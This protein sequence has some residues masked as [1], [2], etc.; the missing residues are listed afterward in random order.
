MA[1]AAR[2]RQMAHP[3]NSLISTLVQD[4]GENKAVNSGASRDYTT[5]SKMLWSKQ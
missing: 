2:D 5:R 1:G 3:P 4:I